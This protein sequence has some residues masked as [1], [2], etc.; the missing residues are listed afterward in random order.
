[1]DAR[2]I[3]FE[4]IPA[5]VVELCRR[6]WDAGHQAYLVGGCTRD[7]LLGRPV[8]DWDVTTSARPNQ[9]QELFARTVPVGIEHGTVA[10][11]HRDRQVEVT[12]F[13]GEGAYSDGRHPDRVTFITE[14]D[15]DL[16][17]R[18]FTI[19][20]MALDPA[21]RQLVDPTGGLRD[22]EACLIRAVGDPE[23]RFAEDGLRPMR[24]VRFAAVLEFDVEPATLAA[25]ARHGAPGVARVSMERVREELL[26]LLEAPRPSIGLRLMVRCGL[27][28]A[29]LP[30]VARLEGVVQNRYHRED[31][32]EH[33]LR[34]CDTAPRDP[35]LR[36]AALLHD[37][38]KPTT[39]APH[40]ERAGEYRFHGHD[41]EGARLVDAIVRRLRLSGRERR[42]VTH[43]VAHHNIPLSG[44]SDAGLRRLIRRVEAEHLDDLLALREADLRGR[45]SELGPEEPLAQLAVLRRRLER[46]ADSGAALTIR[47]LAVDGR[48]VMARLGIRPG[49]RVGQILRQLLERVLEDPSLN[50]EPTLEAMIDEL[51]GADGAERDS[52]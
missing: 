51:A 45:D 23:A 25:M 15:R 50:D 39:A 19:N 28:Q 9:V 5:S 27:M 41:R 10:V 18:D 48:R 8:R 36:L 7:L 44:W 33:T 46:I 6:L 37:V 4:R 40:P 12:T 47:D 20:A 43:L 3:A 29:V 2:A 17:R 52:E 38:G 35:L 16:A 11:L 24:A 26:R 22:L 31:V 49:P 34:V 42:R 21:R 32:L 13:R 14:L 1:M 30:E